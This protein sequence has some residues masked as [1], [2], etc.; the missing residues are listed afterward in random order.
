LVQTVTVGNTSFNGSNAFAPATPAKLYI[1][2]GT[3]T[4]F[5][6][7][8]NGNV[9][10]GAITSLAITPIAADKTGVTYTDAATLYIAGAPSAGTNI[11]LTNP[12]ALYIA[13]GNVYLGGGTANGVAYLNANKV[14]TTGSALSFNG[15]TLAVTGALSATQ[16]AADTSAI[17]VVASAATRT[18]VF[19]ATGSTT[20]GMYGLLSNTGGSMLF[21][22]E[23]SGG[24]NIVTGSGAYSA[25]F[26]TNTSTPV[27]IAV[28]SSQVAVFDTS[29]G[30]K[31]LNTIGVGNTTPSTSGAG[32]TFPATQSASTNANTLDD[33]EE[34]IWAPNQGSGLTVV[35]TFSSSGTYTKVGRIVT[36]NFTVQ[37]STSISLANGGTVCTNLPFPAIADLIGAQGC[38]VLNVAGNTFV[39]VYA[40]QSNVISNSASGVGP[41]LYMT[42]TYTE[43]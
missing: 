5:T 20:A 1:G 3:V 13:A 15:S 25:Y 18:K 31:V 40:Y 35:G 17:A 4:D 19:G 41:G 16:S 12:Y 8:I 14:L 34:G 22:V 26:G 6:T 27:S 2:T 39:S 36:I 11:T 38:G 24:G 23:N 42:I 9:T 37:G 10:T 29:G 7:P 32:I 30:L 43:G 28:N 21:G 33:Y